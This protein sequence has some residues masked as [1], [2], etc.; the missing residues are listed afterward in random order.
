MNF[1]MWF[2]KFTSSQNGLSIIEIIGSIAIISI[3]LVTFATMSQ[4]Y[5]KTDIKQDHKT[6]ALQVAEKIL[7]ELRNNN[8]FE[9]NGEFEMNKTEYSYKINIDSID[10]RNIGE[11]YKLNLTGSDSSTEVTMFTFLYNNS[12]QIAT[13]NVSWEE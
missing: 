1:K 7:N 5:L 2:K 9:T 11:G 8:D 13:V 10:L 6:D 3:V 4:I 12:T